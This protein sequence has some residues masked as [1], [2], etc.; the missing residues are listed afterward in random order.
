VRF[1]VYGRPMPKG[2]KSARQL[3]NGRVIIY[4]VKSAAL[5]RWEQDVGEAAQAAGLERIAR[6]T[7][8][9]VNMT[10]S[11]AKPARPGNPYVPVAPPDGDKL[12]RATLDGLTEIAYDD[13]AQIV[14]YVVRLRY[15]GGLEGLD[16]PGAVI[17]VSEWSVK[18]PLFDRDSLGGLPI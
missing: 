10:F 3:P 4:D 16:A 15:V 7:A 17:E 11:V 2:S 13:D 6:P 9:A 1:T 14:D 12:L 8:V 5:R 18:L